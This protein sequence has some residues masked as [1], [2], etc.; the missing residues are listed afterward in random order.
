MASPVY[1]ESGRKAA[2]NRW[3]D[4]VPNHLSLKGLTP[5]QARDITEQVR[6]LID[7]NTRIERYL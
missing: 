5:Q 6:K 7:E 1:E 3:R 2:R 4:H